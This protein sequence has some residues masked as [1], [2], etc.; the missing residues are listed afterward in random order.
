[1]VTVPFP[2]GKKSVLP[3]DEMSRRRFVAVL[4]ALALCCACLPGKVAWCADDYS[5]LLAKV[6]NSDNTVDFQ[7]LRLAYTKTAEYNP[8]GMDKS[9]DEEMEKALEEKKF[10]EAIK[11]AN[12]V[13]DNNYVHFFA[14][15]VS[16]IAYRE[17]GNQEKFK[18]HHFVTNGLIQSILRSGTGRNPE[19]ALLVIDT[20][21]EYTI[22]NVLGLKSRKQSTLKVADRTYDKLDIVD[23]KTGDEGEIFF[24]VTIPFGWLSRQLEKKGA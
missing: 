17:M 9:R 7:A 3:E 6:K 13:L 4:I 24:D 16:R 11:I 12:T 19:G 8:Y 2:P 20:G 18:Y 23:R 15:F 21:E 10:E 14:H 5:A 1:M 22:L